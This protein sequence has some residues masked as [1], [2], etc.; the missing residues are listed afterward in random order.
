MENIIF[1]LKVAFHR[2][3]F[4]SYIS[5]FCYV[6]R[7]LCVARAT[8]YPHCFCGNRGDRIGEIAY[9]YF[10]TASFNYIVHSELGML[11]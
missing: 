7:M 9:Q 5:E 1:H 10:K 6:E 8:N 3:A 4:L 2:N 11:R